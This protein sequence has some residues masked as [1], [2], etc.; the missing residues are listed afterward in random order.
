MANYVPADAPVGQ[1]EEIGWP[2]RY[3]V[4][5]LLALSTAICYID[6]VNMSIAIIPL[7]HAKGYGP[8]QQGLV[9]SSFLW[10][11]VCLQII[12]GWLADRSGGK[13]VL[14]AG[15]TI[16]SVAT[17]FTPLASRSFGLL[18]FTRAVMGAGEGVNF[19]ACFSLAARW[20]I[21]EERARAMALQLS[22]LNVG[23]VV[24]LMVSPAIVLAFGWQSLFYVSG[25]IGLLWLVPWMAKVADGPERC[26]GVSAQELAVI[27]AGRPEAPL[28]QKIP[29][30]RIARE[31]AVW[32]IV[33]SHSCSAFGFYILQLWLP[34]YLD[35]TFG[36]KMASLGFLSMVPWI[37]AFVM[38]NAAGWIADALLKHGMPLGSVRKLI[39]ASAFSIGAAALF[40]LPSVHSAYAAVVLLTICT[41]ASAMGAGGH[42][43]N[44]VDIA[45][46][47]AGLLQ[48]ITNSIGTIPGIIGSAA[49]G[50]IVEATHSFSSVFYL[51]G[52]VYLI[53][54][55]GFV[56]LGSGEQKIS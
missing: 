23:T 9:L 13:K 20:I 11:Y 51:A 24:G 12:G 54:L 42:T 21:I 38:A 30:A 3:T 4:V 55:A 22:S 45:P 1:I 46:R 31:Q 33:I 40:G 48:G 16:W 6:R 7:A 29:W 50:F 47:Y 5:I 27:Q 44:H 15:V 14:A 52:C 37:A 39:A 34:T 2:R 41:G 26:P 18:L 25:A 56:T 35:R 32:A 49:T 19:P 8:A 17:F 10:G 36:V 28:A 53:G 43:I